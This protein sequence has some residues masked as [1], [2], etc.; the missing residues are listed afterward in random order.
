MSQRQA[1]KHSNT[2]LNGRSA[3][4]LPAFENWHCRIF[5]KD[6]GYPAW[7][8]LSKTASDVANICRAK[9]DHSGA[10]GKKNGGGRPFF[11][12]TADEAKRVFNITHPTFSSAIK[13]LVNIGFI[14][15]VRYGGI[16]GGKGI[17]AQYRLSEKWKSWTS[18]PRDNTNI[19]KARAARRK[20]GSMAKDIETYKPP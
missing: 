13:A 18:P 7:R 12:F 1:A 10:T 3:K 2:L 9:S 11:E 20:P 5:P 19:M 17:S 8:H 14:E 16:Q 6:M 4:K 15:V